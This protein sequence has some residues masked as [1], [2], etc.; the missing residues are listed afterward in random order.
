MGNET[1][2]TRSPRESAGNLIDQYAQGVWLT[3]GGRNID[4]SKGH[5][6][7]AVY[8][9]RTETNKETTHMRLTS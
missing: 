9:K 6:E 5:C 7:D 2:H 1:S 3:V 8:N 4:A